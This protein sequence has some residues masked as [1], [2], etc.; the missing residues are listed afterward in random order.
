MIDI[1]KLKDLKSES[2]AYSRTEINQIFE[3][4]TQRSLKSTNKKMLFDL[5]LMGV[6]TILLIAIT[7][8]L[9]LQSRILISG[10]IGIIACILIIHYR[11]KYILLNNVDMISDGIK[12]AV[13]KIKNRLEMYIIV[14]QI[15]LPPLFS[16]LMIKFQ[17]DTLGSWSAVLAKW[18]YV[19][20]TFVISFVVVRLLCFKIYGNDINNFKNL[21]KSLDS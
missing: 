3:L 7:F 8:Y 21:I 11:I 13:I 15:V 19:A 1:D 14:Y 20:A 9:G 18:Y 12:S 17:F 6:T 5:L 16:L 10:Q 2:I 4:R